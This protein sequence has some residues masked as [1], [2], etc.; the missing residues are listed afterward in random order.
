MI[1]AQG[2]LRSEHFILTRSQDAFGETLALGHGTIRSQTIHLL[3][4]YN[5]WAQTHFLSDRNESH[6]LFML[7]EAF[8]QGQVAAR[9][10]IQKAIGLP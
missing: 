7:E 3:Q 1:D 6:L 4:P 5:N 10:E 2:R 8:R 9:Q